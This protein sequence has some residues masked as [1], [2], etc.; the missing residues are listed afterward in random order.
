MQT[1]QSLRFVSFVCVLLAHS[2]LSQTTPPAPA[3]PPARPAPPTRPADGPGAPPFTAITGKG[4]N[5]PINKN[6]DFVIGP[7]YAP[8]PELNVVEGVPQGKIQQFV[9]DSKDSKFYPGIA[10]EVFGTVDPNN[11]K[12]LIVETHAKPYLR[13]I[14]VYVPAQYKSGKKAPFIVTHDG[15]ALD[16][17]DPAL[18]RILDNL[19]AQK[20]VPAMIAVMI[21]NGGG[22]AQGSQ[23]GLEYDT[24]SGKFAEFIEAE[25]LPA[26]EKMADV[27]L[28]RKASGRAVMGCSSGAAAA[29]SMAWNHPEWYSKIISYSGTYVNQQWPFNQATPGGAW[30]YHESIIPNAKAKPLRIWMHVGD[31]DLYN[32]NVM[33]DDMHDWVEANHRM[34][35]V[36]KTKGYD[37]QYVYALDSG[38]C[39]KKVREQTL[40]QALEWVWRGYR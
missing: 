6:G 18:P 34:A 17:V 1:R 11:P 20:R 16:K 4:A 10:R 26:V 30:G 36:L 24:M 19:I 21:Q 12:T 25:V 35:K 28:T 15:P 3:T 5:A 23:R 39:D 33:R 38:H 7:D 14:T 31:R 2:A 9:M 27:K 8:A 13:T 32:P 40:P 22:D 29:L 37:Y